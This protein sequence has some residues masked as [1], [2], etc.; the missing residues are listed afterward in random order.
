MRLTR[1]NLIETE[2]PEQGRVDEFTG[3]QGTGAG[4]RASAKGKMR[5]VCCFVDGS[6]EGRWRR[7]I[8]GV[9]P[10]FWVECAG[11]GTPVIGI[12]ER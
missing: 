8:R 9:E 5:W 2:Q 12:C 1:L 6:V 4:T 11:C 3:Y 7:W 10:A